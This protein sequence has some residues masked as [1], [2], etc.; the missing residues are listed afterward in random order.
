MRPLRVLLV[1]YLR[2]RGLHATWYNPP[3]KLAAGFVRAGHAVIAFSDRDESREAT[4]FM[5]KALGRR[6]MARRLAETAAHFR[7]HLVL[8]G[9]CDLLRDADYAAIRAAAPGVRFAAYCVDAAFRG[10][11]MKAFAAR[12]AE[13][14]AAF[15]TTGDPQALAPY[16]FPTGR[17]HFM[18][19]PVDRGVETARVWAAARERLAHDGLFLG[20]AIG[21]RDAQLTWLAASLPQGFRFHAAGRRD[22][23]GSRITSTAFLEA[24]ASGAMSPNLAMYEDPAKI[25][26]LYSS[27]RIAL[28]LGL[29]LTAL[30]PAAGG[31][32]LIYEDGIV[33]YRDRAELLEQMT[34]LWR[35]DAERR[36]I[37]EIGWRLAHERTD[38]ALIADWIAAVTLGET[39][40]PVVWPTAPLV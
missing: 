18:P 2:R 4:L 29:G 26:R 22:T 30:C 32:E 38:S 27:D 35:D 10:E 1:G 37:G 11:T 19:N 36:R 24:L 9:H 15:V 28:L 25:H 39:P 12:V 14:D 34:R 21:D 6:A 13:M 5:T 31:L 23:P 40:A 20:T 3:S 7:P 8:F 17:L 16:G 33:P